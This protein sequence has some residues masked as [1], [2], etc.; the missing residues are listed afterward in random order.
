MGS[1]CTCTCTGMCIHV[2]GN[3]TCISHNL[4][5]ENCHRKRKDRERENEKTPLTLDT[6]GELLEG[7]ARLAPV[8]ATA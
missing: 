4:G 7:V 2:Y 1:T 3:G 5:R 6:A 8:D